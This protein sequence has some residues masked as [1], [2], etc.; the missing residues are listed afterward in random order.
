VGY[1]G[2]LPPAGEKA[3]HR[4]VRP[5][6]EKHTPQSQQIYRPTPTLNQ[7]G[8]RS[9]EKKLTK[10]RL[11]RRRDG[12]SGELRAGGARGEEPPGPAKGRVAAGPS[13]EER[14]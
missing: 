3:H 13:P 4:I 10:F 8:I 12:H 7:K 2:G 14:S 1:L 11:L 6:N 5:C 9:G